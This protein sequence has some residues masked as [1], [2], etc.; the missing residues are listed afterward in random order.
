MAITIGASGAPTI[1]PQTSKGIKSITRNSAGDYT[2]TFQDSYQ[3]LLSFN[4]H[5]QN[6]TGI[7][8]AGQVNVK[9]AGTNVTTQ[10]AG[11]VEFVCSTG[12]TATD[13]ASGDTLYVNFT[14]SNSTAI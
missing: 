5:T 1:S 10:G 13:P 3:R 11:T 14:L 9:T 12:G 4:A 6:A 8:G 7:S 2:V